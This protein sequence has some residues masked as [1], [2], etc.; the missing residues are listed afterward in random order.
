M[1]KQQSLNVWHREL[2]SRSY[3]KPQGKKNILK[4]SV[5]ICI[6]ESLCCAS[7]IKTTL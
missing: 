2:Y 7:E 6:T 5:Y 1:D 3:D 4:K